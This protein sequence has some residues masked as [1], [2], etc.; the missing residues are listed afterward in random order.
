M[1]S[2][3]MALKLAGGPISKKQIVIQGA[4]GSQI[5]S[6]TTKR[7]TDLGK[8]TVTHSCLVMPE[9]PYSL[10]GHDLLHK[11]RAETRFIKDEIVPTFEPCCS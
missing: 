3:Y 1:C 5:C 2:V 8:G 9:C 7:I 11:L 6:W 10:L 4:T